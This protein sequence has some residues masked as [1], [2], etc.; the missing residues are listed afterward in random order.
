M[1]SLESEV[2]SCR[3]CKKKLSGNMPYPPVYSFGDPNGKTVI[4]VGINPSRKEFEEGFLST[5][6]SIEDRRHSQLSYFERSTYKY[7]SKIA[8]FFSGAVKGLLGW[9]K[10]PWE[11]VGVLDLVKCTTIRKDGQ[12]NKMRQCQKDYILRN[13]EEFI[14]KQL[15]IYKPKIIIPY[16]VHVC[17]W[18]ANHLNIPYDK[19]ESFKVKLD[20]WL[21]QGIF[22]PQRQGDHSKPEIQWVQR[23]LAAILRSL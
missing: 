23:E 12:W 13:C 6:K 14:I 7:F 21:T 15:R 11:K 17:E 1:H 9:E 16:G 4:L 3:R 19:Y 2:H 5:S 10:S 22:I 20:R 18:L 8:P